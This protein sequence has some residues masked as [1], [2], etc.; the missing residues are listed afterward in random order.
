MNSSRRV[1][2][3]SVSRST[4]LLV[5]RATRNAGF[6]LHSVAPMPEAI[7]GCL[8]DGGG[9][10]VV[11]DALQQSVSAVDCVRSVMSSHPDARIIVLGDRPDLGVV[12]RFVRAGAWNYLLPYVG[13]PEFLEAVDG[14]ASGRAAAAD[15]LFGRVRACLPMRKVA[16]GSFLMSDGSRLGL[17]DVIKRCVSIGLSR[18]EIADCV[19]LSVANVVSSKVSDQVPRRASGSAAT[20]WLSE[21]VRGM[22]ARDGAAAGSGRKAASEDGGLLRPELKILGIFVLAVF[23]VSWL[24]TARRPAVYGTQGTV[25]Y[26]GQPIG[27]GE[28]VFDPQSENG[29]RRTATIK[30]GRFELPKKEGFSLGQSYLVRVYGYRETDEKYKNADMSQSAVIQEQ[31]LPAQYNQQTQLKFETTPHTLRA[32][33]PLELQ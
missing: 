12:A 25:S 23:G 9:S 26:Q 15:T 11:L 14:A 33:L 30:D 13:A 6:T 28:I 29:Q 2:V 5:E 20:N 17:A 24:W 4:E 3:A 27:V 10:A 22:A 32:G 1:V 19:G 21:F 8:D 16:D 18:E 31:F 7:R